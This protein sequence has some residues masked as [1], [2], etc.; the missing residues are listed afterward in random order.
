MAIT[1]IQEKKKQKRLT[2]ALALIVFAILFIVW[3]GLLREKTPSPTIS[4]RTSSSGIEIDWEVL[5]DPKIEE[6]QPFEKITPFEEEIGREN[7]FIPY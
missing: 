1:F 2:L 3:W 7:P 5:K 6:L 4:I